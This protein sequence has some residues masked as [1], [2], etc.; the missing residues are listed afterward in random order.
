MRARMPF[1]LLVCFA[2]SMNS[3]MYATSENP[4]SNQT[5]PSTV[6]VPDD[7]S[8]LQEALNNAERNVCNT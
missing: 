4:K 2:L 5:Q 6:T 8:T 1:I 7:F 3:I